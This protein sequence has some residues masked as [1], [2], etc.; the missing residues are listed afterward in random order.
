MVF[1]N[2]CELAIITKS[3]YDE[4]ISAKCTAMLTTKH[5]PVTGEVIYQDC[6]ELNKKC[7]CKQY[8]HGC[9]IVAVETIIDVE[10]V[11]NPPPIPPRFIGSC[12]K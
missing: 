4:I 11:V 1:C 2:K 7:E 8:T 9:P 5:D 3:E 6:Y 12:K 10:P